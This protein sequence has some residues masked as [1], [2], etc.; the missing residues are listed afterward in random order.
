M[1]IS[2]EL[3]ILGNFF[4]SAYDHDKNKIDIGF[5]NKPGYNVCVKHKN[6]SRMMTYK[7]ITVVNYKNHLF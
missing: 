5:K 4:I 6:V 3:M 7:S 2:K 1:I